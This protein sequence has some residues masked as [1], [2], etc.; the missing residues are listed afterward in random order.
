MINGDMYPPYLFDP[1]RTTK[2]KWVFANHDFSKLHSV[3]K[4]TNNIRH[5]AGARVKY[6][7]ATGLEHGN[8]QIGYTMLSVIFLRE[9]NRICDDL[10][11]SYPD[12]NDERLFDTAR[13]I[14][15]ILLLNIILGEYVAQVGVVKFPFKA[16]PGWAETQSWYRSNWINLEFSLLY[17]WHSM[18]PD[19]FEI[20]DKTLTSD[21]YRFNPQLIYE[22]GIEAIIT[23]ASQ[24]TA[25]KIGLGNTHDMFIDAMPKGSGN[26]SVQQRSLDIAR[27]FNLQPM[28]VYRRYFG[29]EPITD[30]HDLVDDPDLAQRLKLIYGT[31]DNTE[32]M[33]GIFAEKHG[34]R[35]MMGDLMLRMVAY[36]AFTHAL[37][38][39]LLSKHIYG[40]QT[41]SARGLEIIDGTG[42]LRD[43]VARNVRDPAK[44]TVS[45][46]SNRDVAGPRKFSALLRITETLDFAL[47]R[48]WKKF[49]QTKRHRHGASVFRSHALQSGIVILDPKACEIFT[50]W[51]GRLAK[52]DG[53]GSATVPRALTGGHMPSVFD[54]TQKHDQYKAFY[55][56]ILV[57]RRSDFQST[58][59]SVFQRHADQWVSDDRLNFTDRLEIFCIDFLFHWYFDIMVNAADLRK[60]YDNIFAHKPLFIAKL[61]PFSTYHKSHQIIKAVIPQIKASPRFQ[62]YVKMAKSNGLTDPDELAHQLLFLVGMNNYLGLQSLLKSLLG[63]MSNNADMLPHLRQNPDS[64]LPFI[65]ETLRLHPPV[66]FIHGIAQYDFILPSSTGGYRIKKDDHL[67]GVIPFVQRDPAT[68]KSP[69][70][71]DPDR[72]IGGAHDA[73]LI[74]AHAQMDTVATPN[75]HGC[76][77]ADVATRFGILFVQAMAQSYDWRLMQPAYWDEKTYS[78]NVASP[79]GGLQTRYFRKQG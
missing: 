50:Q 49:Y 10:A 28:N 42:S 63:E 61:N 9:H 45:F 11:A 41:F 47:M 68:Y 79:K 66:F 16:E 13:A 39:P 14:M 74:W 25:G 21:D 57:V 18:V 8:T 20:G 1:D 34:S 40:A 26:P 55:A 32:W 24:Q 78:L 7:F 60:T 75:D 2:A 22:L 36:D 48:G 30:F 56:D 12:W 29:L 51:D 58:F 43:I 52:A 23:G 6:M 15:T 69:D 44:M 27:H 64:T 59:H 3:E 54:N 5:A 19:H 4:L 71:F 70:T 31:P 46:Q 53:F 35:E 72:H 33:T 73:D 76:P 77:G 62:T 67:T 38:N 17:R 37:T 65:K